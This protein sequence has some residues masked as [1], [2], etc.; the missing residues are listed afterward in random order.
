MAISG[1]IC[2]LSY[3]AGVALDVPSPTGLSKDREREGT[4]RESFDNANTTESLKKEKERK[5]ERD[6]K[7]KGKQ[8]L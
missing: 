8:Q 1:L 7:I 2:F 3:L 6:K 4:K 5:R